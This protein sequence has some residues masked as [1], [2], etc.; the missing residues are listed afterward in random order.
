MFNSAVMSNWYLLPVNVQKEFRLLILFMERER[1]LTIGGVWPLN[2]STFVSVNA[3]SRCMYARN[4]IIIT[5]HRLRRKVLKAQMSTVNREC[6]F[7]LYVVLL[8]FQI[9]RLIY[10]FAMMVLNFVR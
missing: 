7:F 1:I 3:N 6:F 9:M 10:S 2:V 5:G 4:K 8:I